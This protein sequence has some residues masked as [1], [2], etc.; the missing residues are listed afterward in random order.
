M[1]GAAESSPPGC[2]FYRTVGTCPVGNHGRSRLGLS[3]LLGNVAEWA[4]PCPVDDCGRRCASI[5]LRVAR[6]LE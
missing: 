3:D 2:N 4:S 1:V 5:G 6:A